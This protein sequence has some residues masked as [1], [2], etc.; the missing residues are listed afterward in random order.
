M[1]AVDPDLPDD[2]ELPET[3]SVQG[4]PTPHAEGD[5][6]EALAE[7]ILSG[8]AR[9]DFYQDAV[10]IADAVLS[11][12]LVVPVGEVVQL[13]ASRRAA[14]DEAAE[15]A[16]RRDAVEVERDAALG[17]VAHEKW[18]CWDQ[19]HFSV[20]ETSEENEVDCGHVNP[21]PFAMPR[22]A[23]PSSIPARLLS[24]EHV[25]R[26]VVLPDGRSGLL[27]EVLHLKHFGLM[28]SIRLHPGSKK[29]RPVAP[30]DVVT[31]V[32]ETEADHG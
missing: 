2:F 9:L 12:G 29:A 17:A 1:N 31:L 16:R 25:G 4:V 13:R 8:P 21:Y 23:A 5:V 7:A 19:A 20:C 10:R 24:G 3:V 18:A 30:D 11:S 27:M 22:T 32:A 28:T 14:L 15:S 26:D 6:R